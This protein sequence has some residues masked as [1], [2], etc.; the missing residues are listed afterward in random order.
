MRLPNFNKL[1]LQNLNN[2]ILAVLFITMI[3]SLAPT[4]ILLAQEIDST[5]TKKLR[6][7]QEEFPVKAQAMI[8]ENEAT[9]QHSVVMKQKFPHSLNELYATLTDYEHFPEFMPHTK[10]SY[11]VKSAGA[12]KWIK[13][14]LVFLL[15]FDVHYTLKVNHKKEDHT[16]L[17][18]WSLDSGD[19]FE[20]I[21]GSW[22]LRSLQGPSGSLSTKTAQTGVIY[23]SFIEPKAPIPSAILNLLTKKSVYDLFDALQERLKTHPQKSA[24][25]DQRLSSSSSQ[26]PSQAPAQ[27]PTHKQGSTTS[28]PQISTT[29]NITDLKDQKQ[30]GQNNSGT[31]E[32]SNSANTSAATSTM[33]RNTAEPSTDSS[34][35]PS[36]DSPIGDEAN[37]LP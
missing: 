31:E 36:K 8:S 28:K 17:I 26:A 24:A 14:K 18:S 11:V 12:D 9:G 29:D 10:V 35:G 25:Y 13:Y 1:T 22:Q 37:D 30:K 5:E 2:V 20:D 7:V 34:K 23:T 33:I 27:Q 3:F 32:A 16:A 21:H 6:H 15:W 4:T 19:S